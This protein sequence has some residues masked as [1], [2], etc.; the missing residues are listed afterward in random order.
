MQRP[1]ILHALKARLRPLR[2]LA[3]AAFLLLV[4]AIRALLG[5]NPTP[6][7]M[8]HFMGVFLIVMGMVAAAPIPWQWTGDARRKAPFFRGL[9]QALVW[10]GAWLLIWPV[11]ISTGHPLPAALGLLFL[12]LPMGWII[13]ELQA[14]EGDRAEAEA[15]RFA[16]EVT[17]RQAQEQALKAQ[18]DPHV[19]YNALSGISELI[20]EEPARAERAVVS[21]AELYRNL[22]ALARR[23]TVRLEEERSL[24]QDYLAV[25]QVRLGKRLRVRWEWPET[26]DLREVPPLLIQPLVENAIKHGLAPHKAGGELRITA[27]PEGPGLRFTVADDGVPLNPAWQRGTGLSNLEARLA[28]L[29]GGSRLDLRQAGS[30][31]LAELWLW[32][33]SAP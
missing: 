11:R 28:I 25:E 24:V 6:G 27:V 33:T 19:L 23:D 2:W 5:E 15:A 22:T 3:L 26:L 21:L 17:A 20:R 10:D 18:L 4:H 30:W 7:E 12:A 1:A 32:P 31:T 13:A 9:V 29:G 14:A 16:M 8:L